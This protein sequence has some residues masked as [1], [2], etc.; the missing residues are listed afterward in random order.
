MYRVGTHA[1]DSGDRNR[2]KVICKIPTQNGHVDWSRRWWPASRLVT[3]AEWPIWSKSQLTSRAPQWVYDVE[4]D[5]NFATLGAQVKSI[6]FILV[7]EVGGGTCKS[8]GDKDSRAA[9]GN[10][11]DLCGAVIKIASTPSK[12]RDLHGENAGRFPKPLRHRL[13][14]PSLELKPIRWFPMNLFRENAK[15]IGRRWSLARNLCDEAVNYCRP[16]PHS[17]E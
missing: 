16:V 4:I 7:N 14:K 10:G 12:L 2:R 6:R 8:P 17:W 13:H 9:A 11:F 15:T 5:T 3:C 1:P